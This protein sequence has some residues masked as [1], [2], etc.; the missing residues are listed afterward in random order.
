MKSD[1]PSFALSTA[2]ECLECRREWLDRAERWR[3][4][5][6]FGDQ[7]EQGLYC[8]VCAAFEFDEEQSDGSR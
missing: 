7:P 3:M 6:I 4:Y 8:P 2:L 5:T 1:N